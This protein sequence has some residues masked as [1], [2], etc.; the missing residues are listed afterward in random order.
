MRD[1][2][3]IRAMKNTWN[4]GSVSEPALC[5]C[6]ICWLCGLLL[7]DLSWLCFALLCFASGKQSA[8]RAQGGL[9]HLFPTSE[10]MN[11]IAAAQQHSS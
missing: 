8:E 5:V 6:V 1:H 9:Q 7:F 11:T 10:G 2:P 3:V 4:A